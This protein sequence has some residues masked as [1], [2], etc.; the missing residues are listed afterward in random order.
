MN[1]CCVG[2]S[3]SRVL[4]GNKKLSIHEYCMNEP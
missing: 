3:C 4:F 2:H 1:K